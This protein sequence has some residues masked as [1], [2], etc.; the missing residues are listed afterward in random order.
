MTDEWE[1]CLGETRSR[2][3]KPLGGHFW[4]GRRR[5]QCGGAA[6]LVW[7]WRSRFG[8]AGASS[9]VVVAWQQKRCALRARARQTAPAVPATDDANKKKVLMRRI[10]MSHRAKVNAALRIQSHEQRDFNF[11]QK[12]RIKTTLIARATYLGI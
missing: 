11:E 7:H 4:M 3:A 8:V 2:I 10:I 9:Q 5:F 6:L 1:S 12:L